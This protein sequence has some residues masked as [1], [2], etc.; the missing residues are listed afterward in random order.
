[1]KNNIYTN[2]CTVCNSNFK[3]SHPNKLCCSEECNIIRIREKYNKTRVKKKIKCK[4]CKKEFI[5]YNLTKKY[6]NKKCNQLYNAK[7]YNNNINKYVKLRFE[8]MKR[9][10]FTCKYCGRNVIDDNIKIHIDHII[11]KNK[12]GKEIYNNLIVSCESCNLGKGCVLLNKNQE[13]K[14]KE[15]IRKL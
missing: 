2:I 9:D 11:P 7:K 8:I 6:C 5:T 14:I 12:G 13:M 3:T 10:N 1:M 4:Y 15:Y